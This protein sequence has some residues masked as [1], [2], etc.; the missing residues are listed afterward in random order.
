MSEMLCLAAVERVG[1]GKGA[2]RT[3]R[4]KGLVPAIIYG[5]NREEIRISLPEKEL[6][7]QYKKGGFT[8]TLME[9]EVDKKKHRV[10][11]RQIQRH[12]VTENIEHVDF[13]YVQKNVPVL[14]KVR[15]KLLNEDKSLGVKRGGMLNLVKREI[16]VL[17]EPDLIPARIEIDVAKMNIGDSIR[18]KQVVLPQGVTMPTEGQDVVVLTIVGRGGKKTEE[19]EE[20]SA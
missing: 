4:R 6:A 7:V 12:P 5:K 18:V 17:C 11:A 3:L 13:I 10:L 8:A 15:L 1:T 20:K 14:V 19:E 16:A 2:A 9:V